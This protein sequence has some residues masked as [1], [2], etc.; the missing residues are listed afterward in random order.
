MTR[1][2]PAAG[3]RRRSA[4]SVSRNKIVLRSWPICS[5]S[6]PCSKSWPGS[7]ERWSAPTSSDSGEPPR[8]PSAI[9]RS[10][11]SVAPPLRGDRSSPFPGRR[12]PRR[13][14]LSLA[15]R[16]ET[17]C[18]SQPPRSLGVSLAALLVKSP[19]RTHRKRRR[20]DHRA[21]RAGKVAFL[22]TTSRAAF[23]A[24]QAVWART[25]MSG[26]PNG[27]I[28]VPR[29]RCRRDASVARD[30]Q[31]AHPV[32]ENGSATRLSAQR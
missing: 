17:C 26:E 14:S 2:P 32:A 4:P 23:T 27:Q 30:E 9:R 11:L 1:H 6:V 15:T 19:V 29:S 8:L 7:W 13:S 16:S 22:V 31:F 20:L 24:P 12:S 18:R 21:D 25:T 10:I 5:A 28:Q 3:V